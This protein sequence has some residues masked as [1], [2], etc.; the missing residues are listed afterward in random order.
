MVQDSRFK[1]HN[2]RGFTLI[3]LL[4]VIGVVAILATITLLVLNPAEMLKQGRDVKRLSE[5]SM[6]NN[7]LNFV[8]SQK[9]NPYLGS[10]TVVYVSL[11]DTASDCSS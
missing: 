5:L 10:S 4:I 11:P 8:L 7:A 9:T 2:K 6:I 1:I 3:E